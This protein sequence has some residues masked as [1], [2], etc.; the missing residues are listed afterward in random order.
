VMKRP[1]QPSSTGDFTFNPLSQGALRSR[2]QRRP[3]PIE[4]GRR[5]LYRKHRFKV[6]SERDLQVPRTQTSPW[7]G[8]LVGLFDSISKPS[9]LVIKGER[10]LKAIDLEETT[11]P[12][13]LFQFGSFNTYTTLVSRT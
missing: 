4:S 10:F 6:L 1:P 5:V 11:N 12:F 8:S 2:R 9:L 13:H 3:L 7:V